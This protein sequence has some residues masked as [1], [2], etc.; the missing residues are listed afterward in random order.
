MNNWIFQANPNHFDLLGFLSSSPTPKSARWKVTRFAKDMRVGDTVYLWIA[1][2]SKRGPRGIV[3]L[4]KITSQPKAQKDDR[5]GRRFWT[6]PNEGTSIAIRVQIAIESASLAGPPLTHE[7][8]KKAK[9][10]R[11]LGILSQSQGTNFR[12]T[13][14][15]ADELNRL[16]QAKRHLWRRIR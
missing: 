15:Q 6:H 8:L 14:H 4:A 11:R 12:V 3:G 13:Q 5:L 2:G 16:W 1:A 9:V 10:C 7:T